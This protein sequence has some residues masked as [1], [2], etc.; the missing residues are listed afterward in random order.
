MVIFQKSREDNKTISQTSRQANSKFIFTL[1]SCGSEIEYHPFGVRLGPL[2]SISQASGWA[3]TRRNISGLIRRELSE[4]K[5]SHLN[6]A[7]DWSK[8]F[9]I[10]LNMFYFSFLVQFCIIFISDF[11]YI[12]EISEMSLIIGISRYSSNCR[13]FSL[14]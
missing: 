7:S 12:C 10:V 13:Y 1:N 2:G 9:T 5:D 6:H 11:V 14:Y 8:K 3:L 4:F